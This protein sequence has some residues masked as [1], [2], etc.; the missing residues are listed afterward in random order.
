M[1][2]PD[3]TRNRIET[4]LRDHPVVLFMK[5]T[6]QAPQ[7]GFSAATVGA[8]NDLLADYHTVNVLEDPEI[9]EGVKVY[10]NWPTI[11]QLYVKGDLV[12]GA[13]IV[14][15]MY[16]SGELH[17]LLGLPAPD[18]TPPQI[19]ISEK[20]VAAIRE[21]LAEA[22][23]ELGIQLAI[24]AQFNPQ[25]QL[26]PKD[27]RAIVSEANGITIYM[28]PATAQRARGIRIDWV[29]TP[30]GAGLAIDNPNAPPPV[31][32]LTASELKARLDAGDI[33]LIDVRP[34]DERAMAS[35]QQTFHTFDDGVDVLTRMPKETELAFICHTGSRSERAAEHF[36]S[37]GFRNVYN[38]AGGIDAWSRDVDS[39]VPRY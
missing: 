21:A 2:L 34:A 9:R 26:A 8:L 14:R 31:K 4:M 15:S 37:L 1:N 33:A 28:D 23:P 25:F 6:R 10:G 32:S 5:G 12:G 11:P 24:D 29:E 3:T 17:S 13:D 36:R 27:D 16:T 38:V 19:T 18:R 30:R 20:A 39:N 35:V 7:C 22:D